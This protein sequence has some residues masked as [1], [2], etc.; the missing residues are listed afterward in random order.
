MQEQNNF[1][2]PGEKENEVLLV[3]LTKT[4]KIRLK[5]LAEASGFKCVSNYVR[6]QL[7]N[8]SIENKLNQILSLIEANKPKEKKNDN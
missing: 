3:R 6:I 2:Q 8:P 5:A 7:L 4:Q 1:R